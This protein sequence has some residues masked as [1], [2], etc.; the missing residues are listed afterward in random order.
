M[1]QISSRGIHDS[2]KLGYTLFFYFIFDMIQIWLQQ[3]SCSKESHGLAARDDLYNPFLLLSF[4][5]FSSFF[6]VKI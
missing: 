1:N 2:C 5:F 4:F 6:K 3:D